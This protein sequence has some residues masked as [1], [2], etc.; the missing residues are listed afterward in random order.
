MLVKPIIRPFASRLTDDDVLMR[1][2]A[3]GDIIAFQKVIE[4]HAPKVHRI[5]WRL[6]NDPVEAEDMTQEVMLKIWQNAAS[7]KE[8]SFGIAAW[9]NRIAMNHCLDRLKKRPVISDHNIPERADPTLLADAAL[10]MHERQ[11]HIQAALNEL[12]ERQKASIILTYFEEMTNQ[13]AADALDLNIKAFESL[14]LRARRSLRDIFVAH[15]L[16]PYG[17]LA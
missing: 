15:D 17:E 2:V 1:R 16:L 8:G 13:D 12:P 3:S 11:A 7:W 6:L 9:V 5:A 10:L 14:L 4:K